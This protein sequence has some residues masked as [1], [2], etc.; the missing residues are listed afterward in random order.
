MQEENILA[1]KTFNLYLNGCISIWLFFLQELVLPAVLLVI[2]KPPARS[3]VNKAVHS[4]VSVK[5]AL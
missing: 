1:H 2:L 5:M 3:N 4:L